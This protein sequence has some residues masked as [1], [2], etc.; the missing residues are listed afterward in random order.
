M[1]SFCFIRDYQSSSYYRKSEANYDP[2]INKEKAGTEVNNNKGEIRRR[3][4]FSALWGRM[5]I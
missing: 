4:R 3:V 2:D 1:E 5:N